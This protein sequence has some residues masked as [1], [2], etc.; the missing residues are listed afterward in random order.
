MTYIAFRSRGTT[1][2]DC[3]IADGFARSNVQRRVHASL[4]DHVQ[5]RGDDAVHVDVDVRRG[6]ATVPVTVS[7]S[8]V[9]VSVTDTVTG[10][11]GPVDIRVAEHG[12]V[13]AGGYGYGGP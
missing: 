6:A 2:Y 12:F 1:T 11:H 7:V 3:Y 10:E 4:P 5:C 8:A 9:S 13:S